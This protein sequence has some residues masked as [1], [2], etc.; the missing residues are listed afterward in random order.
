MRPLVVLA[1]ILSALLAI[2][3]STA[4]AAVVTIEGT[5][6]SVDA[7]KRTIT[8]EVDSKAQTLDVSSKAKISVD[9]KNANLDS[10]K[11]GQR[12]KLSYHKDLEIVLKIEAGSES[13]PADGEW[14]TLSSGD[15]LDG[16]VGN[17]HYWVAKN[18]VL[19]GRQPKGAGGNNLF[20]RTKYRNFVLKAKVKV[21]DGNSGIFFRA[22]PKPE[23]G[24]IGYQMDL[25]TDKKP[26]R[27]G[28]LEVEPLL[29]WL[30]PS[31]TTQARLKRS[32]KSREWN[33]CE[34][35]ADGN[36]IQLRINGITT[37]ETN[38]N[39]Y[40]SGSIGFQLSGQTHVLLKDIRI[41][42]LP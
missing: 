23:G 12:A 18:G 17:T 9:E 8:V 2:T 28:G 5:I 4:N 14:Q 10:L 19:T 25:R 37:M 24:P 15:S 6:K 33:D 40:E 34:I 27:N 39:R 30:P 7:K 13:S 42:A 3:A 26:D 1:G 32:Y 35:V 20:S 11:P 21:I 31:P 38:D 29:A 36:H 16:W 22:E 41:K